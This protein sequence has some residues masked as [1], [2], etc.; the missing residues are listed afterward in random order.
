MAPRRNSLVRDAFM[1]RNFPDE[2]PDGTPI[3]SILR[4]MEVNPCDAQCIHERCMSKNKPRLHEW[5]DI[6]SLSF[7]IAKLG[8]NLRSRLL[9]HSC[10]TRRI[11][12]SH[13]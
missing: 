6:A 2:D 10:F 5:R 4:E 3:K 8:Q 7:I 11:I 13:K 9:S 12:K 1:A